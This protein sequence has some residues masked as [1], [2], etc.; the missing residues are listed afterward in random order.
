MSKR[1]K[2][3]IAGAATAVGLAITAL[4]IPWEGTELR[5]YK[6]P[7]GIPTICNGETKGVKMGDVKTAEECE[8]MTWDRVARDFEPAL[9]K[10]I[11]T[12][13]EAPLSWQAAMI[14][15]SYNI[16]TGAACKSTAAKRAGLEQW[17]ASCRAMTWYNKAGGKKLKGL[18]L[19][20]TTGDQ[21]RIGEYELCISGLEK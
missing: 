18:V 3:A 10:C 19:R 1:A 20:R 8:E 4:I 15:L 13:T 6:D 17:E 21:T 9:K 14:S 16:G 7:I 12:Y 5:A 2:A 11:S